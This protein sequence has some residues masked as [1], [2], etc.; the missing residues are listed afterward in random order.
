M[1]MV[2]NV[3]PL[4]N[5]KNALYDKWVEEGDA[6]SEAAARREARALAAHFAEA[7]ESME[8]FEGTYKKR[9]V[10]AARDEMMRE[11]EEY[12]EEAVKAVVQRERAPQARE[13]MTPG[14]LE[15][16]AKC[17]TIARSIGIDLLKGLIPASPERIR[18]ALE[19]G[20]NY[21]NTIPLRKWDAAALGIPYMEG[22]S[23][24]EKVCALKHVA[25]FHYA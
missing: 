23:L 1:A 4:Y 15:F 20:D 16:A 9:D 2:N 13:A 10:E 3:E 11:F 18:K 25:Q 17:D 24:S 7:I 19:T 14:E 12:R 5:D 22:L 8:G 6:W 21:L